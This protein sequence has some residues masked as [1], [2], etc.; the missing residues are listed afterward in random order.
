MRI[1]VPRE[2]HQAERR[3]PLLPGSVAKLVR[4]GAELEVEQAI[5]A[6]FNCEDPE[7]EKAGAKISADR[8]QS[9]AGADIVLRLRKPPLDE[10]AA[11]QERML[12]ASFLDPSTKEN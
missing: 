6:E 2:H 8:A 9:L 11:T 7:Y 10:V 12:Q 4:V 5:G 3:V 1:F